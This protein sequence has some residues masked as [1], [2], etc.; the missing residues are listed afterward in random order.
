MSR[1]SSYGFGAVA[2]VMVANPPAALADQVFLKEASAAKEMFPESSASSRL[3]ILLNDDETAALEKLL[4]RKVSLRK[5][6]YWQVMKDAQLIG[7]IFVLEVMA[8]TYP[9]TFA[10]AIDAYQS[11]RDVQVLIYRE[12]RGEEIREKRFRAQFSGKKVSDPLQLGRDID[13]ISG[14]TISSRSA[15]YA[16]KKALGLA[17]II[18]AR[19]TS[20]KP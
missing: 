13:A 4:G 18:A 17:S 20:V 10:V 16:A 14:A 15:S 8:Q 11:V 3:E 19:S 2:A 12:P 1:F 7:S 6:A 9:I 5:Y